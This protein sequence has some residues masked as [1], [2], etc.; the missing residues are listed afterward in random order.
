[1]QV[2][3]NFLFLFFTPDEFPC[4][5][6]EAASSPSLPCQETQALSLA[7]AAQDV[8]IALDR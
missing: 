3:V 7:I 5:H 6:A 2:G 1:L 4:Q 8:E